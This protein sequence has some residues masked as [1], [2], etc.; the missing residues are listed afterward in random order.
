M[1]KAAP[2]SVFPA[3]RTALA[4]SLCA[5]VLALTGCGPDRDLSEQVAEAKAAAARAESARKA[6]ESALKRLDA[7]S[8][9]AAPTEEAPVVDG[10]DDTTSH[11]APMDT[12][13]PALDPE[14]DASE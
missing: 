2:D 10:D 4:A 5:A 1:V 14:Q 9:P 3:T 11:D 8:P 13:E 12:T 6:A 7:Q